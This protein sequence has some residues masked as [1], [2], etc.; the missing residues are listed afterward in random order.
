[1]LGGFICGYFCLG[2]DCDQPYILDILTFLYFFAGVNN[3]NNTNIKRKGV[4]NNNNHHWERPMSLSRFID[5]KMR[6]SK[7]KG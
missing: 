7:V 6:R 1:M 3:K 4:R 2:Y 5:T